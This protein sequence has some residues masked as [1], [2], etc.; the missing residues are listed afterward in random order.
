MSHHPTSFQGDVLAAI[1]SAV[2]G[3]ISG[4][5][6]KATGGGGHF[7]IVVTSAAFAGQSLLNKQRMVLN[8]IAHL[9]KGEGAPVHA[10]D[11]LETLT[12]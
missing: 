11:K 6:C 9:M 5:S 3:A 12:P 7:E 4:A 10:V 2:E 8:A 1:K